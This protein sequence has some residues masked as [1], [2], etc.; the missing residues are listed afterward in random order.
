M[1]S[2]LNQL[3]DNGVLLLANT[4]LLKLD[5]EV[6]CN[7][8]GS[9]LNESLAI[10]DVLLKSVAVSLFIIFDGKSFICRLY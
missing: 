7:Q 4:K 6:V 1:L 2:E 10:Q 5:I 9:R 8:H 3:S